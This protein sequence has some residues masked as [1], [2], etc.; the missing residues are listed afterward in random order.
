MIIKVMLNQREYEE[1]GTSDG[2]ERLLARVREIGSGEDVDRLHVVV[3]SMHTFEIA[4]ASHA[5]FAERLREL[6]MKEL[7]ALIDPEQNPDEEERARL[8]EQLVRY[9]TFYNVS[10]EAK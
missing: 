5:R 4:P 1:W 8:A 9:G 10:A 6:G 3:D 7:A 2:K